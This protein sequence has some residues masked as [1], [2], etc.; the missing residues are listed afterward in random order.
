[1][2]QWR[3][4]AEALNRSTTV[5]LC[6]TQNVRKVAEEYGV[7]KSTLSDRITGRVSSDPTI[8]P[9]PRPTIS[10]QGEQSLVEY[11]KVCAQIGFGRT[12]QQVLSIVGDIV[13]EGDIKN[14]FVDGR[15]GNDWWLS[16]IKR[17]PEVRLC[18]P[19][20][21]PRDR[22]IALNPNVVKN[23]FA[24]LGDILD[25]YGLK[26]K[27]E[28]IFNADETGMP[29][30][31]KPPKIVK[32]AGQDA[33]TQTSGNKTNITVVACAS[34]SGLLIP[35][36]VIFQGKRG[37]DQ[38]MFQGMPPGTRVC[39]S[40]NGWIDSELFE[41][42]VTEHFLKHIPAVRPVLLLIDGHSTHV[43]L[44][45]VMKCKENGIILFALPPHTTH[46]LQPLDRGC[47]K[48]LKEHYK[49][50]CKDFME[51]NPGR[52]VSRFVFG[53]LF[54]AVYTKSCFDI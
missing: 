41:T 27:P 36:Q 53:K 32:V 44:E 48:P 5:V 49:K 37:M 6:R 28:R 47:F 51:K 12:K 15:P 38:T 34:A 10:I 16:F 24:M 2:A 4:L 13:R 26:N 50:E 29:L 52:V 30:D 25:K 20:S 7:P 11:I 45:V 42:W 8:R 43:R 18:S 35:P 9:G 46:K 31:H 14:K 39:I 17:W 22:A 3:G 23:Y 40:P 54:G 19:Q 33:H 1:M 21:L